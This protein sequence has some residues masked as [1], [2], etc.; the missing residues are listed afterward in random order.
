MA[1]KWITT[2]MV[3]AKTLVDVSI[4]EHR[5]WDHLLGS[6]C[7]EHPSRL[8]TEIIP[9]PLLITCHLSGTCHLNGLNSRT[10][11][12]LRWSIVNVSWKYN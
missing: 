11:C 7:W 1:N 10:V 4:A 9:W 12:L 6:C 3:D 2:E 5:Y 8:N